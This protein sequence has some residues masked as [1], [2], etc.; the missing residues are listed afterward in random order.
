MTDAAGTERL[1]FMPPIEPR[2]APIHRAVT[3]A[4]SSAWTTLPGTAPRRGGAAARQS[5][6]AAERLIA[7]YEGVS[8]RV[9]VGATPKPN[10]VAVG[11]RYVAF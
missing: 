3:R 9:I 10:L 11:S 8:S 7:N 1:G 4:L 5:I 6:L 2:R